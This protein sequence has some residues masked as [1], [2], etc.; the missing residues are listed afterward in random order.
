MFVA[1][2]I[3]GF[4]AVCALVTVPNAPARLTTAYL[5][6]TISTFWLIARIGS[7]WSQETCGSGAA[8]RCPN[9]WLPEPTDIG[10]RASKFR[11]VARRLEGAVAAFRRKL[12]PQLPEIF[13]HFRS[14][15][16]TDR[17]ADVVR[18]HHFDA[19]RRLES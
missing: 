13:N 19:T 15:M 14:L 7:F 5:I 8:M 2:V 17:G 3:L 11:L 12:G 9:P 4:K 16:F 6:G 10:D 1:V 18:T